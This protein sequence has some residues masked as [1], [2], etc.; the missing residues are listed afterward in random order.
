MQGQTASIASLCLVRKVLENEVGGNSG[1]AKMKE[2]ESI[3]RS[4]MES[5][6]EE[7]REAIDK[8][9]KGVTASAG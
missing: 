4:G 3:T 1:V 7:L 5:G 9:E 2:W 8:E 6:V